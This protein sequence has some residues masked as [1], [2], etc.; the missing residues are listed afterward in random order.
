MGGFVDALLEELRQKALHHPGNP[1]ETLYLGGGT[2]SLLSR[3]QL[4]R[5]VDSIHHYYSFQQGPEWTIECNPDDLDQNKINVLREAGFNRLSIGIQSFHQKD[6]VLMRR[7]HNSDQAAM[8]VQ[9]AR[10]GGFDNISMDL[11]YG[12]PGQSTAEWEENVDKALSLPVSH[13]SAYHL[14]Y[15]PGTV[16]DHWRKR[17]KLQPAPEEASVAQ[18]RLL[19][20]KLLSAGYVHYELSNFGH[21]DMVSRH[22]MLYWSGLP[23]LG[24]G[25]SAHSFDGEQR[26]W[27]I[28]S[29]KGYMEGIKQGEGVQ[30]N[31]QLSNKEKYHDYLISSLRTANGADLW[32][33][34]TK[35]GLAFRTHLEKEAAIFIAAGSMSVSRGR[36]RID[37]G[38]WLITDHILR[39]L[40]MD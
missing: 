25:P 27:N 31:E 12:I 28:S 36:L 39:A 10:A 8:V 40:F 4:E 19:R 6:L 35:Y 13:L 29:I 32:H 21:G 26:S 7:S 23:Y 16:F 2:P 1:L 30:E 33:V 14:T 5:I 3:T 22:N 9:Q 34:E 17:G 24:L 20:E 38:Q 37:P 18:Y 11:I 15:E